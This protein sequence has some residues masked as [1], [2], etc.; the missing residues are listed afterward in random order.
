MVHT[1]VQ[2]QG[3]TKGLGQV[4]VGA[5]VLEP[6]TLVRVRGSYMVHFIPDAGNSSMIVGLGLTIVDEQ[7]FTAGPVS[8]PSPTDDLEQD[9]LWHRLFAF[10]PSVG[11]EGATSLDQFIQGEIDG[12]AMRKLRID[13]TIAF[14]WDAVLTAGTPVA[15]G[16]AAIRN[17][18]LVI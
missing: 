2:A 12:K 15:E 13:D 3:A 6:Q 4:S 8:M 7:A 18:I 1:E 16:T 5:L 14:V 17:L 10:S 9:W 11:G